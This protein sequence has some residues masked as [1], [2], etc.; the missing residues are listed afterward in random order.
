MLQSPN[1]G[2]FASLFNMTNHWP[3]IKHSIIS[4]EKVWAV[5]K[6]FRFSI[7]NRSLTGQAKFINLFLVR[8]MLIDRIMFCSVISISLKS[9]IYYKTKMFTGSVGV[10]RF[11]INSLP[12][13]R[14]ANTV[15]YKSGKTW[16]QFATRLTHIQY[17][18]KQTNDF[19]S[20]LPYKHN[21]SFTKVAWN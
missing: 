6:W 19:R 13:Y 10:R 3:L 17:T 20:S 2:L 14:I 18:P 12:P 21:A 16:N 11:E 4:N 15:I 1:R 7:D 8:T 9:I 5:K